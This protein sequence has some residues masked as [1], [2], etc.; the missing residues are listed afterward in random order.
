MLSIQA[1]AVLIEADPY[2]FSTNRARTCHT[3]SSFCQIATWIASEHEDG[4]P[5]D[6]TNTTLMF[7][8]PATC[9]PRKCFGTDVYLNNRFSSF[10]T[11]KST[12]SGPV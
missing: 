7:T 2:F 10:F 11:N 1:D 8:G 9:S 5:S 12:C 4:F 3:W 6:R